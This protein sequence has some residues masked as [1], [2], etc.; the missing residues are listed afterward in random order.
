VYIC[1][2]FSKINPVLRF[3]IIHIPFPQPVDIYKIENRH[4]KDI[5]VYRLTIS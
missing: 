3:G 4:W 5:F 2:H 1:G